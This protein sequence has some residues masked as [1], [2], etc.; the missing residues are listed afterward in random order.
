MGADF[1]NV[2]DEMSAEFY[3]PPYLFKGAR[4]TIT[5][6]PALIH[7]ATNFFVATPDAATITSAV[8]IRTGA[9]T[10]FFDQNTRFVPLTFQQAAGGLTLTAPANGL[11]APPGYYMLFLLNSSGVP[12]VAPIIQLI[13]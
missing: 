8:L 9:V 6:A 2:P 4:P 1:G 11:A 3:S 12:S 5:Q 7:F 10:H 13:Q